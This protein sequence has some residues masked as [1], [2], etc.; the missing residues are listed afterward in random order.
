MNRRV[1]IQQ[2]LSLL[3]FGWFAVLVISYYIV[4]KPF[5]PDFALNLGLFAA[6]WLMAFGIIAG[7][8]GL[9]RMLLDDLPG[10]PLERLAMQAA[11]GLGL[12]G[13]AW[14]A[15]GVTGGFRAV[16]AWALLGT[17]HGMNRKEITA[18]L[19]E[20]AAIKVLWLEAGRF[21]KLLAAGLLA[22]FLL[23][24]FVA[25]APPVAFDTL[26]YHLTLPKL[27]IAAGS[28][29]YIP[30]I[31][32]WGMPQTGEMLY[33]WAML[34]GGERTAA[35]LGWFFGWLALIGVAGAARRMLGG[36]A[37]FVAP[38][39]L[40]SGFSLAAGLASGYVD[41]LTILF[42]VA[43]LSALLAWTETGR[44]KMLALSGV[45]AGLALGT[46][47]TAGVLL[48]CGSAVIV[49]RSWKSPRQWLS[50]LL[51]YGLPALLAFTPWLL[52]NWLGA[53]SPVYPLVF[54]AG[55]MTPLRLAAYQAGRPFGGWQD[56]FLLPIRATFFGAE[57][58]PGYSASIGP[59]F[60]G[61][62]LC[63]VLSV[64]ILCDTRRTALKALFVCVASGVLVWMIAG[65]FSSYLLQS[66]LYFAFFPALAL[67][68]GAG[69]AG[70]QH[71]QLPGVRL[72]R[73]AAA[74]VLIVIGLNIVELAG[75]TLKS[76]AA[77]AALG[78]V[79][80]EDY[81]SNTL[82]WYA[83][84]IQAVHDLPD[85]SRT[86]LLFEPRSLYCQPVCDPDEVLDRWLRERWDGAGGQP[87]S[88]EAVLEG[89]RATGYTHLLLYQSGADFI[90]Q[91]SR[92]PYRP[93][94]WQA[95]SDLISPLPVIQKF[96][97]AYILYS[98]GP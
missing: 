26:V 85:G 66:R 12:L 78:L 74:L 81:L 63:A 44:L 87:R 92:L 1:S 68:A 5:T 34:L 30:Q 8:G 32:F 65:R 36:P 82:G 48:I 49:W 37:A 10:D 15:I 64:P 20:F 60:F 33:T 41:W 95:L 38:A 25:A 45:F 17:L 43:W 3:L 98:L 19:K 2:A 73:I 57:G 70:I 22:I 7:A 4:H 93:E 62:G 13:I 52:K 67:L 6:R 79:A 47:Y 23:N 89:W 35:L 76:G 58:G 16:I 28:F 75:Q 11:A 83:P 56:F 69:Y 39:A 88:P 9:G 27:Y 86:L 90:H 29:R 59:L 24:L 71:S 54:P 18:W 77:Q 80:E 40:V 46:K 31:M 94:D 21:G 91:E 55:A 51:A 61:L 42:S 50:S 96:G 72:G 53:G 14:L 84:A 97:G